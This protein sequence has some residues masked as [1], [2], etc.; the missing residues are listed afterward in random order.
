MIGNFV[1]Q[2]PAVHPHPAN[3]EGEDFRDYVKLQSDCSQTG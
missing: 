3:A 1:P 2:F